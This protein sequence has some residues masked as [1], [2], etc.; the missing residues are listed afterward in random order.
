LFNNFFDPAILF[1]L[2]GI[3]A[4]L[5]RSNLEIPPPIS[6]FLSLY[7]LMALGLKGG[8]AL[9]QSGLNVDV[10]KGL[11]AA[12]FLAVFIPTIGYQL[13]KRITGPFDAAAIAA[14]YGSVSAVTFMTA[15]QFLDGNKIAYSG[16]MSA[17]MAMMESP[18]ILLAVFWVNG[19]RKK[20]SGTSHSHTLK[21]TLHESL[22]DGAQLLLL[23]AM[24]VGILS[25][26]Q[27]KTMMAPFSVDLF[28]GMLAFFLLDMGL[29]ASRNFHYLKGKSLL[30]IA[31]A[32]L[33]PITHSLLAL[34]LAFA[35]DMSL[36]DSILLMVL[37]SSASYIAVPAVLKLAI[38]EASPSLYLGLSLGLTFPLN[39]ILG[40]P[41]YSYLA[42][43][44]I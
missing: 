29:T 19:I 38:P 30:L 23:G 10:A 26:E 43:W 39:I 28:K 25:G 17:A 8:F 21:Q 4:G 34:G 27:G 14:T 2:F 3:G 5:L 35:L 11:G 36:G 9:S 12:V 41:F 1:F 13:L 42:N 15:V 20:I 32:V 44:A 31:Y 37:A 40:I 6:K 24:L 22:T 33:G 18:A 16:H 7:L